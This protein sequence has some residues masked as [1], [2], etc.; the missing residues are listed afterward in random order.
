MQTVKKGSRGE[1]VKLLQGL[2]GVTADGIFGVKTQTAVKDYQAGHGLKVDGIC[3][4]ATWAAIYPQPDIVISCEDL[5][6]AAAPHGSMIY[7][8]D[9][10]YSTY[11]SG[12]CGVVSFAIVQRAYGLTPA[13]ESATDT[14]QRLGR[15]SWEH[16][17][18]PKGAGTNAGLFKTN[19]T[20]YTATTSAARIE[21]AIRTGKL[22][23]LLIKKGFG[24][25]TGDGHYIVAYAI[26]GD[27]V[28]LRDV[29][30]SAASRQKIA[31]SKITTGLKNAYIMEKAVNV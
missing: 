29:G 20:K 18:R 30:T 15:Y 13:G 22:V 12:G 14:I 10:S 26:K 6:Q 7:G 21:D 11:K 25:Y 17:F 9:K 28:L 4:P 31:L 5:K 24:S 1:A 2:L 8:P 16:G 27:T 19:G 3:G 23:I